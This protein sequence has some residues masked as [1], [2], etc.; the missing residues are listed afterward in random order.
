MTCTFILIVPAILKKEDLKGYM[1]KKNN[2]FINIKKNWKYH[3]I[4]LLIKKKT[5]LKAFSFYKKSSFFC[6]KGIV[7]NSSFINIKIL[8]ILNIFINLLI[9][10]CFYLFMNIPLK[11]K[12]IYFKFS[13][14]LYCN[15]KLIYIK[16][17]PNF[18][19]YI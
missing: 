6:F 11:I 9:N 15:F 8:I 5:L 12:I 17:G 4:Y 1:E 7:L 13:R 19:N 18:Y 14:E 16:T 2:Y 10:F 3:T